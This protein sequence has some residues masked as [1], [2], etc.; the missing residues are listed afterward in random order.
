MAKPLSLDLRKW[1]T[2]VG[3]KLND[4][5]QQLLKLLY[6]ED[7]RHA[8]LVDKVKAPRDLFESSRSLPGRSDE[9][10]LALFLHRLSLL[11]PRAQPDAEDPQGIMKVKD[12]GAQDCIEYFQECRLCQPS[13]QVD[14]DISEK[15]RLLECLVTVY[16]NVSPRRREELREQLADQVG[17]HPHNFNIFELF[18]KLFQ[19][20]CNRNQEILNELV[21]ALNNAPPPE[22]VI[23]RLLSQLDTHRIPHTLTA[24]VSNYYG[25]TIW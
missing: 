13:V 3:E 16:V 5:G 11:I 21:N 7:L 22:Q 17:V 25:L 4:E 14:I 20:A 1:L 6:Y 10:A 9:A 2:R 15:S 12:L 18:C 23:E 19:R 8:P 24:G